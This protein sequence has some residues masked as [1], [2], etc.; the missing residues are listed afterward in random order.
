MTC[1]ATVFLLFVKM[2]LREKSQ[3]FF[4]KNWAPHTKTLER[5]EIMFHALLS[6]PTDGGERMTSQTATSIQVEN[7][8]YDSSIMGLDNMSLVSH[9]WH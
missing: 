9:S 6:L 2:S 1:I 8:S 4:V 7:I 5:A 3:D